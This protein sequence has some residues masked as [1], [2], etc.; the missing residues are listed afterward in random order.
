MNGP[1]DDYWGIV[2]RA[3]SRWPVRTE[4]W[5][6]RFSSEIGYAPTTPSNFVAGIAGTG[7]TDGL[8]WNITASVMDFL[9]GHSLGINFARTDAGWLLS[10]QYADNERL[11]EIRYMW[12]PDNRWTLD[13]RGRWR[14]ELQQR[15]IDGTGRDRFDFYARLSWSFELRG[16][17]PGNK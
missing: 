13:I 3:A 6:L 9:P 15:L 16:F 12:R 14:D 2:I 17:W 4:G 10:P 7:E 5:R 8:A 1:L 11:M